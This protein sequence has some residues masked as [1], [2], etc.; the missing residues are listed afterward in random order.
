MWP[1]T[2]S[3]GSLRPARSGMS[4]NIYCA[5][6]SNCSRLSLSMNSRLNWSYHSALFSLIGK[7][8]MRSMTLTSFGIGIREFPLLLEQAAQ[9]RPVDLFHVV[10]RQPLDGDELARRL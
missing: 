3:I 6:I 5:G 1:T 7:P 4:L 2:N 10:A 8:S 9:R